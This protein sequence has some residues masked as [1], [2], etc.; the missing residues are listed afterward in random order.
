VSNEIG[1]W[2]PIVQLFVY[3]MLRWN[4]IPQI[5]S[6]EIPEFFQQITHQITAAVSHAWE[7]GYILLRGEE[8]NDD[9]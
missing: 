2:S 7:N 5:Y 9:A 8:Q 1:I 3:H 6:Q 4:D